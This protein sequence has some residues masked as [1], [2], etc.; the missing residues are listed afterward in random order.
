MKAGFKVRALT[1]AVTSAIGASAYHLKRYAIR[2]GLLLPIVAVV[3]ALTA[4]PESQRAW[5]VEKDGKFH[6]DPEKVKDDDIAGPGYKATLD[7]ERNAAKKAAQDLADFQARFKDIDPDKVREMF[8]NLENDEELRLRAEG[9]HDEVFN[10]KTEKLRQDH[11]RQL[12]QEKSERKK[13]ADALSAKLVNTNRRAL[14]GDVT[15]AA[16]KAGV[17]S[18][19]VSDAVGDA[20]LLAQAEGWTID[21]DGGPVQLDKDGNVVMGGKDVTKPFTLKE[22]F[23]EKKVTKKHWFPNLNSGG[24]ANGSGRGSGA[25]AGGKDLS[26]LSPTE[27]MTQARAAQAAAKR[28]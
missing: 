19:D 17:H 5:Y 8:A 16:G 25:G 6:F 7:K 13:E 26:G 14:A 22:W 9:K 11:A 12:E 21:D 23:E 24:G 3:D 1:Q 15:Q 4:V 20:I 28:P 2:S 18:P 10:K 27:R